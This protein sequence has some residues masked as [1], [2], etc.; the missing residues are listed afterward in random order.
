MLAM[1]FQL[2]Q[3]QWLP[4]DRLRQHQLRQ[5]RELLIHAYAT[6]PFYQRRFE[7]AGFRTERTTTFEE[8]FR[9][10]LLS[11][12]EVQDGFNDL[13]S[14]AVP[15]THGRILEGTTSGSV[16]NPLKFKATDMAYFFWQAFNLKTSLDG[17]LSAPESGSLRFLR[18]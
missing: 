14:S 3:S 9:L 12:R 16:G 6:V 11:R 8:F 17:V 13:C 15:A 5:L 4:A 18:H 10:P 1:Q 2:G 7:A